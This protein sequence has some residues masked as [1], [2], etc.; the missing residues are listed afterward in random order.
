M[1]G[2]GGRTIAPLS[3][4]GTKALQHLIGSVARPVE[5]IDLR[6]SDVN[7]PYV[8]AELMKNL[9]ILK[10]L[11][12]STSSPF[13]AEEIS[14]A[15]AGCAIWSGWRYST[16]KPSYA[17]FRRN[18]SKELFSI[19]D[20][21]VLLSGITGFK[22][23]K[24]AEILL[25]DCLAIVYPDLIANRKQPEGFRY[26]ADCM[27]CVYWMPIRVQMGKAKFDQKRSLIDGRGKPEERASQ[28]ADLGYRFDH[29]TPLDD[30]ECSQ[31]F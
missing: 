18:Y 28:C 14:S 19:Y 16:T 5:P 8:R 30:A 21:L 10:E 6:W 17:N 13:I 7:G 1:R 2:Y 4:L 23:A 25:A 3:R 12:S 24:D 11:A 27:G 29:P 9:Y 31:E 26:S 15:V 22:Q 20:S